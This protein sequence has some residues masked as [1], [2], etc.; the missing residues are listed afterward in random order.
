MPP[1]AM[2]SQS[3]LMR[4]A[5]AAKASGCRAEIKYGSTTVSFIPDETVAQEARSAPVDGIDYSRP[6]L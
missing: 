4:I 5:K 1:K 6:D 3:D 2:L